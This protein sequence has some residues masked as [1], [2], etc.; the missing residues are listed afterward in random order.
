MQL[1][2]QGMPRLISLIVGWGLALS[3]SFPGQP[4]ALGAEVTVK[5]LLTAPERYHRQEVTLTGAAQV[6]TPKTS[7]RGHSYMTF[8]LRDASGQPLTVFT[9]GHPR[10]NSG[11]R[12]QVTGIFEQPKRVGPHTF[13][14]QVGAKE[15]KGIDR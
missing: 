4:M 9:W 13:R 5:T 7:Q 12:V 3:T 11:D 1:K 8:Q 15:I 6:V 10:L 14:N 2:I